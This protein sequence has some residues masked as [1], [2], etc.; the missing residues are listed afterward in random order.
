MLDHGRESENRNSEEK[1]GPEPLSEI[2]HHLTV[3]VP[4]IAAMSRMRGVIVH[5]VGAI[6][7]CSLVRAA[8]AMMNVIVSHGGHVCYLCLLCVINILRGAEV[9]RLDCS[10]IFDG[11]RVR[12]PG[13]SFHR[14]AR[15]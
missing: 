8:F 6:I 3:I 14:K 11:N 5:I 7:H 15:K 4:G 12:V 9:P 10:A 13:S 1:A 2:R